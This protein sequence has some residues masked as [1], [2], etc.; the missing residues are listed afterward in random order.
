MKS[1]IKIILMNIESRYVEQFQGIV[2]TGQSW[3]WTGMEENTDS[4]IFHINLHL[5]N[6]L[7]RVSVWILM[8]FL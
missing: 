1:T 7:I 6:R 5:N 8:T 4:V 2:W 3:T